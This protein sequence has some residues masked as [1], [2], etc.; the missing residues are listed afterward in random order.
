MGMISLSHWGMFELTL[1][2]ILDILVAWDRDNDTAAVKAA[3]A[4]A[5]SLFN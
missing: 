5:A 2:Q 1:S 3:E 4:K